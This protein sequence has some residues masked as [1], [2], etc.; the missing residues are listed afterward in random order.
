MTTIIHN[1]INNLDAFKLDIKEV[2]EPTIETKFGPVKLE[3]Q[4]ILF[5][6]NS[7]APLGRSRS[8]QYKLID[9]KKLFSSH[10]KKLISD[11]KINMNNI[12][13]HDSIFEGGKKQKRSIIFKDYSI[14][15]NSGSTVFMRSDTYNSVDMSWMFQNHTGAFRDSC[16][17]GCVF[18]GQRLYHTKQKHTLNLNI[19]SI[20]KQVSE[21]LEIW[22]NNKDTMKKYM[23]IKM[24]YKQVAFLL[25]ETICKKI[26]SLSKYGIQEKV[27]VNKKL[28]E[29]FL[30]KF[31]EQQGALGDTVWNFYNCLTYYSSHINDTFTRIDD[32]GIEKEIKMTRAGSNV[33]TAQVKRE[34][35]VRD[36]LN[37]KLFIAFIDGKG[38]NIPMGWSIEKHI[39]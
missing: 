6:K 3:G 35:K 5:E 29:Y 31:D 37:D 27:S 12:E 19:P 15:D 13:V 16:A 21:T 11:N 4:K 30:N 24:D 17:N 10:A 26:N 28:L 8:K 34:E 38:L 32:R 23:D 18:G 36:L 22:A 20:L 14:K 9:P 25:C 1:D 2:W 33:H 7:L 39:D